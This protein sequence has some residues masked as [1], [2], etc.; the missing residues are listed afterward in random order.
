MTVTAPVGGLNGRDPLA[1]MQ[2]TDAYV[3][4]NIFPGTSSIFARKGHQKYST[5]ALGAPGPVQSLEVYAGGAGDKMLAWA[6]GKI[7][8]CSVPLASVLKT[9]LASNTVITTMFSNAADNSQHLMIAS[10]TD[11]PSRYDGA[12]VTDLALTGMAGAAS[13][14][15]FVFAFK[16]RLYWGQRDKL[17]FYYLPVGALQGALSYFDLAQVSALGGYLVAIATYSEDNGNTPNDYIV[18]ITSKGECIVYGGFDPS[19]AANWTL[20]GRYYAAVPIGPKCCINYAS[21]LV[22]LT[23]EGAIAFSKIRATGSALA[24]GTT[25]DLNSAI[26][27]KLGSYL[28]DLNVNAGVRGWEGIQYSGTGGGW[29][30][31]NV[32]ATG[33]V[34]GAYY[35]YV[36]NTTTNAWCRYTNWNGLCFCVYKGGLYF[37]RADGYVMQGDVGALD[38]GGPI[39]IQA[40]QAY[41][42]FEDG[43]GQGF[44]RKHFQWA[45]MLV[46]S[47]STPAIAVKYSVDFVDIPPEYINS[48]AP[49]SGATWDVDAWDLATWGGTDSGNTQRLVVTLNTAG[50]AGSMWMRASLN[51]ISFSWFATQYVMEKT[52]GLLI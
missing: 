10:G 27:S 8:D 42:Y 33:S 24:R 20:V 5:A 17:G 23:L 19:A 9:G 47:N 41:N 31:L 21:E 48:L 15:N 3:L 1:D 35:H 50:V 29:L 39:L 28:S 4:D 44:L 32:P 52:R 36:M 46:A 13:T 12:A 25:D 51:G 16:G 40:K 45:S 22:I 18:F 34:T 49:S 11:T 43:S 37:G 30:L 38:D 7:Y 6:G 26:T 14:L 2:N